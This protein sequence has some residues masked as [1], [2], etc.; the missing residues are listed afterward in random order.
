[1]ALLGSRD[2]REIVLAL[3]ALRQTGR[4][5]RDEEGRYALQAKQGKQ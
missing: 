2:G 5:V 1:M 4:L 3:D